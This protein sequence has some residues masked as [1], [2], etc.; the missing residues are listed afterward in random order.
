MVEAVK[1]LRRR[2][3]SSRRRAQAAQTRDEILAVATRRFL[4]DGYAATT[5]RSIALD[6]GVSVETI[7][8][9]FGGKTGVLRAMWEKGLEGQGP[10]PAERR[11]DALRAAT[12]DPREL[13]RGWG[14]FS[15]EVAPPGAPV[16]LLVRSAAAAD[17]EMA[18][19]LEEID[20]QRLG[21]M[22]ENAR[23]L[24]ERGQLR[25]G[26]TLEQAR[27]VLWTYSSPDLYELLVLKRGWSPTEY[28]DFIARG[29]IAALLPEQ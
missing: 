13:I 7:H 5:L 9:A 19:L 20:A 6:A 3:D 1:T 29:V 15:S 22:E 25:A 11:S 18:E 27:D 17:P 26:V 28:G 8:K 16:V 14:R 10:V 12:T 4:A 21:R 2:Y 24:Y 23:T